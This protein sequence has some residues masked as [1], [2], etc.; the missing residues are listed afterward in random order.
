MARSKT[1]KEQEFEQ[2]KL[3]EILIL[4]SQMFQ[5]EE[6]T[7]K[8]IVG[9]L[10]DIAVLNLINKYTPFWGINGT[11]KFLSRFPRPV[12]QHLGV[13]LYVQPKCPKLITDWFYTLVEFA[14]DNDEEQVDVE[15]LPPQELLPVLKQNKQE[16]QSLQG[17]LKLLTSSL[18]AVI[19]VFGGSV[20]W[21]THNLQMSP[22]DLLTSE[23]S[24]LSAK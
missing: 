17:R 2:Q 23:Q 7:A 20:A 1:I 6:L 15:V 13:K 10:Y 16:I 9:C 14:D 11:L 12:A 22:L 3:V 21:V 18:V 5:R 24:S 4:L 19:M 8:A